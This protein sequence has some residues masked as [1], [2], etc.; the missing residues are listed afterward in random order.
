MYGPHSLL[1]NLV[2]AL[3]LVPG[4]AL[5]CLPHLVELPLE[6]LDFAAELPD[7]LL[8]TAV[9]GK[10]RQTAGGSL[11]QAIGEPAAELAFQGLCLLVHSRGVEVFDRRS[12]V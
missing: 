4:E 1:S 5:E 8:Q 9:P 6:G 3:H 7:V 10:S 2:F 12:E 11:V